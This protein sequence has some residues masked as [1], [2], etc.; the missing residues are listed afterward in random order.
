[1]KTIAGWVKQTLKNSG[2]TTTAFKL[3]QLDRY[4]HPLSAFVNYRWVKQGKQKV[5]IKNIL[6][7]VI[8]KIALLNES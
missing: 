8:S 4:Q 5:G 6:R 3:T 7:T 1:M 2:T